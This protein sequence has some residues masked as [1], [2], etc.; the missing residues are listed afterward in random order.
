MGHYLFSEAL[1]SPQHP[2]LVGAKIVIQDHSVNAHFGIGARAYPG[3]RAQSA[4]G[5]GRLI[6]SWRNT[7]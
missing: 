5:S 4:A 7:G 6:V 3:Q 1:A 2:G